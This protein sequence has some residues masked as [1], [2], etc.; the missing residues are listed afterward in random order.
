MKVGKIERRFLNDNKG[1][2]GY[3][4]RFMSKMQIII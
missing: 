3:E 4:T 1:L 2:K